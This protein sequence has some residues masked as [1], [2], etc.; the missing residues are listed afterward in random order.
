MAVL[1]VYICVI[2]ATPAPAGA[3]GGSLPH[4]G[5]DS[6]SD[7]CLQCHDVHEAGSDYVL[8]RWR[9]V[10]DT[11][12]SCHYLFM[13]AYPNATGGSGGAGAFS[14]TPIPGRTP[15]YDPG[16]SG[17][18]IDPV[19]A[20]ENSLGSRTSAYEVEESGRRTAIGHNLER[21]DGPHRYADGATA[22]ADY[23]PGGLGSLTAI[24]QQ[25]YPNVVSALSYTGANGLYCGSCHTPHG[26]FGQILS[27][28][29]GPASNNRGKLLSSK[30]NHSNEMVEAR[31]WERDA[32]SWCASCHTKRTENS[33]NPATG[34]VY[35]NHPSFACLSCHA[36]AADGRNT[37]FPHTGAN[38]NLLSLEPDALCLNCHK[39]GRLP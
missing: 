15:A 22:A 6:S 23:I 3:A 8:L 31:D 37:D 4:G 27:G 9:S 18:E 5:Y 35:H 12:G 1:A 24:E 33:V 11:C 32:A 29:S 17:R 7:A 2:F 25:N 21:G 36:N 30:P 10:T 39:S 14:T 20:S 38:E 26:V 19:E 34:Q 28:G 16:Y 13:G